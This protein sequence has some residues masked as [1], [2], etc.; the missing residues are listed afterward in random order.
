MPTRSQSNTKIK[1]L[2]NHQALNIISPTIRDTMISCM[3]IELR[4]GYTSVGKGDW[5]LNKDEEDTDPNF[6][7]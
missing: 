2:V 3:M 5:C 4:R 7:I 1:I 6:S